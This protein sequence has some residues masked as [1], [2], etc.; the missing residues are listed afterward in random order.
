MNGKW[1]APA[2]PSERCRCSPIPISEDQATIGFE[3]DLG[4]WLR[5]ITVVPRL[6]EEDV[7]FVSSAYLRWEGVGVDGN[8]DL[9]SAIEIPRRYLNEVV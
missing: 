9:H 1:N 8:S 6:T 3:L 5:H 7:S 4:W 2:P